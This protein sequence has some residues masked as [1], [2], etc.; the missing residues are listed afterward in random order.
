MLVKSKEARSHVEDLEKTFAILRKYRL[1]LN[2]EKCAFGVSGW[3]FLEFMV[4]QR[5]IEANPAKIEAILDMGL[6]TNINEVQLLTGKMTVFSRFISK[7]AEGLP[8]FKTLRK[9]TDF[10]WTEEFQQV[11]EDL[12]AYLAK[13]PLLVEPM[14]GDTLYLYLSSTPQA[15]SFVLVREEDGGQTPIYYA[16]KVLNG[17]E[18]R[19]RPIE[20]LALALVT[21]A[22]K[23]RRYFFSYPIG[24]RTNT[25]LK[26][27]LGRPEASGRLEPPKKRSQKKDPG[28]STGM[29]PPPH[30]GAEQT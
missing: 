24:V 12:K 2:P 18:C 23:L 17:A 9:V 6:P 5:G 26:Q 3:R 30:K 29:D 22:R 20:R 14:P 4:T 11:F 7:S 10:E 15:I 28:Y 21:T 13:L 8:F 27:V 1:K 16:S 25:P 19:Y